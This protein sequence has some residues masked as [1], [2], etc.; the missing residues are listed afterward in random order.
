VPLSYLPGWGDAEGAAE[1]DRRGVVDPLDIAALL[2]LGIL[3]D[4]EDAADDKAR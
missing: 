3:Y 2:R 4:P 1:E